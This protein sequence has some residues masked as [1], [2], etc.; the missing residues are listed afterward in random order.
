MKAEEPMVFYDHLIFSLVFSKLQGSSQNDNAQIRT[1]T[2]RKIGIMIIWM[3]FCIVKSYCLCCCEVLGPQLFSDLTLGLFPPQTNVYCLISYRAG[4]WH[5]PI[6]LDFSKSLVSKWRIVRVKTRTKAFF[7]EE[8]LI[9]IP[10]ENLPK[11]SKERMQ[12]FCHALK[13]NFLMNRSARTED[14]YKFY[15]AKDPLFNSTCICKVKDHWQEHGCDC[16]RTDRN[17]GMLEQNSKGQYRRA[18]L[19]YSSR[20]KELIC[21]RERYWV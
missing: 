2:N 10:S 14:D 7:L 21:P 9:N 4:A 16:V 19:D 8:I 11:L 1:G 20:G 12:Y 13:L 5:Y 3:W 15:T 18:Y 17:L 6:F